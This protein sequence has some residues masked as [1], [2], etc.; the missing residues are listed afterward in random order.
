[1]D[2]LEPKK[3]LS[4]GK[5]ILGNLGQMGGNLLGKAK[6]LLT[7]DK[8]PNIDDLPISEPSNFR[9]ESSIGWNSET[10]FEVILK[11]RKIF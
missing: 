5:S 11:K 3:T 4:K 2:G 8:S 10:G 1:M 7:Q 6:G 9:H